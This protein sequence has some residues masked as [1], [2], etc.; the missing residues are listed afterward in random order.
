M[1]AWDKGEMDAT[2]QTRHAMLVPGM[3]EST[4]I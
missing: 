4:C 2:A 3:A 1:V